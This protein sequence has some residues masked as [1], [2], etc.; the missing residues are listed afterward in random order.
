MS[1]RDRDTPDQQGPPKNG[2]K[3]VHPVS[4]TDLAATGIA[5]LDHILMGGLP[6]QRVYLV[7]GDPGVGKTTLGLQFLLEGKERGERSLYVTLSESAEELRAVAKSHGWSLDGI[8]LYEQ[9][10]GEEAL[11]EEE[12]TVFYPAEVE[13]GE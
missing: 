1:R 9:L 13:L 4:S 8:E 12:T 10:I 5:G 3:E 2:V 6:R 11:H 7:Q